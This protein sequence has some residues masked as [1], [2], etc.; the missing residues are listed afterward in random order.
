ML[1]V[2]VC[3]PSVRIGTLPDARVWVLV[4]TMSAEA[5]GAREMGV[6]EMVMGAP[7]GRRVCEARM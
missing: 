4:P 7:P 5:E 3:E 6:E 1:A 2:R